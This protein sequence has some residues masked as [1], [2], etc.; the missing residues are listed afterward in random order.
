MPNASVYVWGVGLSLWP[1]ARSLCP[2]VGQCKDGVQQRGAFIYSARKVFSASKQLYTILK[3][4][5]NRIAGCCI[6]FACIS[7]IWIWPICCFYVTFYPLTHMPTSSAKPS[8][9]SANV[10]YIRYR[11]EKQHA[12]FK[13]YN[14]YFR[15]SVCFEM[16]FWSFPENLTWHYYPQVEIPEIDMTKKSNQ[17]KNCMPTSWCLYRYVQIIKYIYSL[18]KLL[19]KIASVCFKK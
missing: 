16:Q 1:Q 13:I 4:S 11:A 7:L 17:K 14:P 3:V 8:L 2:S 15:C 10:S 19:M 5:A 9:G 18:T 6:L 12:R